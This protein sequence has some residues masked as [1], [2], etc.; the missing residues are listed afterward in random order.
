MFSLFAATGSSRSLS[1]SFIL[2]DPYQSP[3]ES[4][5]GIKSNSVS[6]LL[7]PVAVLLA[8]SISSSLIGGVLGYDNST[9]GAV[10]FATAISLGFFVVG[11]I[12]SLVP[13]VMLHRRITAK[14]TGKSANPTGFIVFAIVCIPIVSAIVIL[15]LAICVIIVA[16]ITGNF[17]AT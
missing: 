11:G 9:E 4:Q 14:T 15:L 7:S 16:V 3:Q 1:T 6:G 12:C 17:S 8:G 13:A 5:A 2:N 10:R